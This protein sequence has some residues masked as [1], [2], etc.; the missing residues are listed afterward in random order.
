MNAA[1]GKLVIISAPSGTGKGTVIKEMLKLRSDLAFSVSATTRKP[2]TGEEDGIDYHFISKQQFKRMITGDEFLEYAE[3]VGEFYGTPAKPVNA[4][5]STG[6]TIILD[7]EVQGAKQVMSKRDDA[8]TIF[9]TPPDLEV[10]ESRLRGR[11]TDSEEKLKAR[12]EQARSEL[13]EKCHYDHVVVCDF[14]AR[15]A[16]EILEIIDK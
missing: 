15:A 4:C 3:Y 8:V 5:I 10:L 12:L 11:G 14:A 16:A 13:E 9:L 7:I 2:R 1:N 6:K